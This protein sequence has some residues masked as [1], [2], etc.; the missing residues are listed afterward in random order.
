M[1]KALLK[2][3]GS[4]W[5][6]MEMWFTEK[7]EDDSID[8]LGFLQPFMK[9][10]FPEEKVEIQQTFTQQDIVWRNT[11]QYLDRLEQASILAN[12]TRRHVPLE[13][14]RRRLTWN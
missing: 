7:Q 5:D 4:M 13:H 11:Q 2:D 1:R 14:I 12:A 8:P 6:Q 3:F 10:G 9:A